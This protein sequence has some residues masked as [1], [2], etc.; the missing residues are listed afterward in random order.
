MKLQQI[1]NPVFFQTSFH[2][3]FDPIA[4]FDI[5][6]YVGYD[7]MFYFGDTNNAALAPGFVK[8]ADQNVAVDFNSH[9]KLEGEN[10][11]RLRIRIFP[12]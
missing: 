8:V 7:H 12:R 4:F 2:V 3:H 11:G 9:S 6:A 1:T 5:R 10:R